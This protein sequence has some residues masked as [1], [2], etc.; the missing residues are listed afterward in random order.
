MYPHRRHHHRH[1]HQWTGP[2]RAMLLHP[3]SSRSRRLLLR[4]PYSVT[5]ELV[6]NSIKMCNVVG[7]SLDTRHQSAYQPDEAPSSCPTTGDVPSSCHDASW[8]STSAAVH[9]NARNACSANACSAANDAGR[10]WTCTTAA[11]HSS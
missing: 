7:F 5:V 8:Y 3:L 11:K 10:M 4:L 6:A 1:L 9:G 2:R